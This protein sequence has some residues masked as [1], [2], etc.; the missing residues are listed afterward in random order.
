MD[1]APEEMAVAKGA[2]AATLAGIDFAISD[3]DDSPLAE[4]DDFG[5]VVGGGSVD[6]G[7]EVHYSSFSVRNDTGGRANTLSTE[8]AS[9]A[10]GPMIGVA[11]PDVLAEGSPPRP[12]GLAL[13]ELTLNHADPWL[14]ERLWNHVFSKKATADLFF[15]STAIDGSGGPPFVWPLD[16]QSARFAIVRVTEGQSYEWTLGNGAPVYGP[17]VIKGGLA[18]SIIVSESRAN[19]RRT[20][21]ALGK[22]VNDFG[23][24]GDLVTLLA[25]LAVPGG[26][27]AVAAMNALARATGLVADVLELEPDKTVGAYNALY[28]ATGSWQSKLK[29]KGHGASIKLVEVLQ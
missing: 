25:G 4:A 1:G 10:D 28:S 24:S 12:R 27:T 14:G 19:V 22:I 5:L 15:V 26:F 7:H 3:V 23:A 20:G 13:R 17:N 8:G 9:G 2:A 6:I 21:Q 11:G 29:Q 16:P 18:V